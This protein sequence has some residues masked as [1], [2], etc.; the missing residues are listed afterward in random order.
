MKLDPIHKL[1]KYIENKYKTIENYQANVSLYNNMI[2][3]ELL[4]KNNKYAL[5]ALTVNEFYNKHIKW[6]KESPTEYS[7]FMAEIL[8]KH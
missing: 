2:L 1:L 8:G 3:I 6:I 7:I 4:D 5:D